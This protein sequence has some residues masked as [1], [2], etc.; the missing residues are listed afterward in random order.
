V[1]QEPAEVYLVLAGVSGEQTFPLDDRNRWTIGRD[2]QSTIPIPGRWISREHAYIE[3]LET[4]DWHLVDLGSRNGSFVNGKRVTVPAI[5]HEGDEI[6][7]GETRLVFHQKDS[8]M[9]ADLPLD[10]LQTAAT[11]LATSAMHVRCLVTVLVVDIRDFTGLAQSVETPVLSRVIGTWFRRSGRA[12][13]RHGSR[14]CK[15]IGDAVMAVWV[16]GDEGQPCEA[17]LL[18]V[19]AALLD[20]RSITTGLETEFH[21]TAPVRFGAGIN[22]GFAVVGNTGSARN[23]EYTALGDTVNAAFRLESATK[24]VHQDVVL[25][26]RSYTSLS[27]HGAVQSCFEPCVLKLKGYERATEAWATSFERLVAALAIP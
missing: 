20:I 27:A 14:I 10:P 9:L 15:Y 26:A 2:E 22:T 19:L 11:A 8:L 13:E 1:G 17:D 21:L 12:V 4:G 6:R 25:G 3:R 7:F 16:H 23:P 5:L 24:E 18:P